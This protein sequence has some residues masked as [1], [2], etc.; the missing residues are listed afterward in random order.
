[1]GTL[2]SLNVNLSPIR[3]CVTTLSLKSFNIFSE[4]SQLVCSLPKNFPHAFLKNSKFW[5]FL[6]FSWNAC[7]FA[8]NGFQMG[9][10]II[11]IVDKIMAL[12][13]LYFDVNNYDFS[14]KPFINFIWIENRNNF[15][16]IDMK[17][18]KC[19]S[20]VKKCT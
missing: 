8:K 7:E 20:E 14:Q 15:S 13:A 6:H 9:W 1:M 19:I 2:G 10:N 12:F 18:S 5:G 17:L 4:T 11:K 16:E 3:S